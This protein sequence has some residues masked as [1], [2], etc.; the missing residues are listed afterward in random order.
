LSLAPVS[1]EAL[2][3]IAD[4]TRVAGLAVVLPV[5]IASTTTAAVRHMIAIA[6]VANSLRRCR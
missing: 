6:A 2:A 1:A 5:F 4:E 3:L